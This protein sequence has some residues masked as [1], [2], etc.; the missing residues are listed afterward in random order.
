[1]ARA[2]FNT[3]AHRCGDILTGEND[4]HFPGRPDSAADRIIELYRDY[5]DAVRFP[6][7]RR[8]RRKASSYPLKR[9]LL[10]RAA[11]VRKGS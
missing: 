11:S 5:H 10:Y 9:S 8:T 7:V 2:E 3:A 4:G 6:K 1:M